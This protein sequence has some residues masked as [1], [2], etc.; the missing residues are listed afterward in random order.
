VLQQTAFGIPLEAVATGMALARLFCLALLTLAFVCD[1]IPSDDEIDDARMNRNST[2][3]TAPA[4]ARFLHRPEQQTLCLS[5]M[6]GKQGTTLEDTE[7]GSC[8]SSLLR[9]TLQDAFEACQQCSPACSLAAYLSDRWCPSSSS[10][11]SP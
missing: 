9:R 8:S 10:A 1:E 6:L 3:H 4:A 7:A 2:K 5:Q 11:G